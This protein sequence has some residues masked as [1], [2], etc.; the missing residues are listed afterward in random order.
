M[1]RCIVIWIVLIKSH[2][3]YNS[4]HVTALNELISVLK[5][6]TMCFIV[7]VHCVSDRNTFITESRIRIQDLMKDVSRNLTHLNSVLLLAET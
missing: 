2:C 5:C 3:N 4:T 6:H 7:T 1:L